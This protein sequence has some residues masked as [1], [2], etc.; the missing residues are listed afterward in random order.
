MNLTTLAL[1]RA[2]VPDL[3]A[4]Q[5]RAGLNPTGR[6]DA[7]TM[8]QLLPYLLGYERYLV[9][10]GDSYFSIARQYDTTA[11]AILTANPGQAPD[12]LQVGQYLTVP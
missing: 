7:L 2:G 12:R 10:P 9:K 1:R 8:Q 3:R 6:E 11:Q 5:Q 4:F